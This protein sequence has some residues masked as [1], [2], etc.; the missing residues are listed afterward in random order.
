MSKMRKR[1]RETERERER[2][3]YEYKSKKSVESLV[4][5]LLDLYRMKDFNNR[6][7]SFLI[8]SSIFLNLFS[9]MF[10]QIEKVQK[11]CQ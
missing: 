7:Q 8:F 11:D 5:T 1:K 9:N 6:K 4:R 10:P 3:I 2:G